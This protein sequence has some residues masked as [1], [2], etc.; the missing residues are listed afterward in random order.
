MPITENELN[1]MESSAILLDS[2]LSLPAHSDDVNEFRFHIHAIQNIILRRS[3]YR[4]MN[5]IEHEKQIP[6]RIT[7]PSIITE[8]I[9]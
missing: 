5:N 6:E 1:V 7:S 8:Q 3:A 2:F 9:L 4:I